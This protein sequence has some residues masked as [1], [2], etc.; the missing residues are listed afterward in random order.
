M[1]V[2]K[3]LSQRSSKAPIGSHPSIKTSHSKIVAANFD[4]SKSLMMCSSKANEE[5]D[6]WVAKGR[7]PLELY[8]GTLAVCIILEPVIHLISC[9][10]PIYSQLDFIYPH[11]DLA[12]F[13]SRQVP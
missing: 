7:N 5:K 4:C 1:E 13:L 11:F 8:L 2:G 10:Y 9:L 3:G 12:F 6:F